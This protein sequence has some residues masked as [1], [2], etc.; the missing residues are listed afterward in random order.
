VSDST[1]TFL[2]LGVTVAVFVWDHLPVAVVALGVALSLWATGVLDLEQALGGFGDPTVIF[3]ASLFVVSEALDATGVT[4]WAGQELTARSGDSR[5]RV[6]VLM[7]LLVAALTA[8]LS[9]NGSVA[10]LLPVVAVMAIRLRRSPSQFMMPLAFAAHA[11]SLL[12]LTGSPVNVIVAGYADDAGVGRFGFFEF[13]LVGV[14]LVAG[15]IA[16]IVLFGERLLPTRKVRTMRRDFSELART[17]IEQYDVDADPDA[18]VSRRSGLAEIVIPPRSALIGEIVFPGEATESGD[19]VVLAV[20][21]RGLDL[22]GETA[23]AAGDTLLLQGAWH[24][25]EHHLD[26]PEVLLVDHPAAVRRQAVPLGPG[27][28]PALLVLAGMVILLV[29]GFVPAAVAGLLAAGGMIVTRALTIDEAYRGIAWT[30]VILV[31]G[32]I[33]LSTAMVATGAAEQLADALVAAVGGAGPHALL[34]GLVLLTFALGQLISN[35]ATALIVLPIA[36]SA[37]AELDVS[38]K[39]VLMAVCVASAAAFIT[40]VATPANLMVMA[41][42]G[43]RFGDY[44]KLGLP[45]LVLFGVVAV[46]LVPVIWSF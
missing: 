37:A 10:A 32:M 20:Q 22:E 25:L 15:T 39:P 13:A 2:I 34:I 45:L 26:D 19:L 3:I 44:W 28:A 35:M 24:A 36:V 40:P 41:P 43:Y 12:A 17:L 46:L 29:G 27:A 38:P 1:I 4:A 33:P 8:L 14:P 18:L 42:G 31:A 11:G 9:V 6:M 21:R 16:I 30:T 5:A 7:M 23:L